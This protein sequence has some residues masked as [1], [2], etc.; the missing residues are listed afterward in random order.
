MKRSIISVLML[1]C[2]MSQANANAFHINPSQVPSPS[3][4][5]FGQSKMPIGYVRFCQKY[6][7]EC[8]PKQRQDLIPLTEERWRQML[9]VNFS[10]NSSIAPRTDMETYG[11]EE[12][13][14]VPTVQGDCEDYALLKKKRLEALGFPA[15]SLLMTVG[16]NSDRGGHAVLTVTTDMGDF[17][18]DNLETKILSWKDAEI[19]YLKRQSP[20][21]P[22][23]WESLFDPTMG[24]PVPQS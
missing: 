6:A 1:G 9:S 12:A 8:A 16:L 23:R 3:M 4:R 5:T 24:S 18:L 2:A 19:Y 17:I 7:A 15:S 13:W 10:T 21:N 11:L 20:D 22:N 14:E